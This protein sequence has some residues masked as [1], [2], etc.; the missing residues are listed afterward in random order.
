MR[1]YKL[2]STFSRGE[3][4]ATQYTK[5]GN[6]TRCA[7]ALVASPSLDL[8]RHRN[9]RDASGRAG[10][11]AG[12]HHDFHVLIE[13]RQYPHQPAHRISSEMTAHEVGEVR[14]LDADKFRG[15]ALGELALL[16]EPAELD[17]QRGLEL[18]LFGIGE[19]D[20]G[21]NVAAADL[22]SR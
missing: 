4:V 19:P 21:K 15:R 3:I 22:V 1:E 11:L 8:R 16:D 7:G 14:L 20:V 9:E 12:L 10:F 18:M 13:C 5:L 2:S 17:H 6:S